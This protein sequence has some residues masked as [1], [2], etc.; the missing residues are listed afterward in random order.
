MKEIG[1][2]VLPDNAVLAGRGY[3]GCYYCN[4]KGD[5]YL[6]HTSSD[7]KQHFRRLGPGPKPEIT[8]E[9]L[10]IAVHMNEI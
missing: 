2:F 9:D 5:I 8:L 10:Q 7:G 6:V 3:L 4:E 1:H